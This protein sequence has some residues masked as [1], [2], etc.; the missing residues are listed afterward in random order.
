MRVA[1]IPAR[2]GSKR[3]PQKNIR[4]FHGRPMMAWAIEAALKSNCFEHVVVSTDCE[5]IAETARQIG[6]STPFLRP[7][8]LA[9]DVTPLIPVVRQAIAELDIILGTMDDICCILPTAPMIRSSDL[10]GGQHKLEERQNSFVLSI[11][12]YPFPPQRALKLS[13]DGCVSMVQSEHYLTRSQDLEEI[14]HDAGQFYWGSRKT[15][16]IKDRLFDEKAYGYRLPRHRV[17]DIDTLEDWQKAEIMFAAVQQLDD[18]KI[19]AIS[20][21][22]RPVKKDNV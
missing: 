15:W 18:F 1:I 17:Q 8:N 7:K 12:S 3:I 16:Q 5:Q 11:T 9:D 20:N 2:S 19:P 4:P 21:S 6:A 22:L 13:A 10:L 14:Y